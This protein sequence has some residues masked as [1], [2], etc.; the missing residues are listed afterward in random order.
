MLCFLLLSPPQCYY[1]RLI[2]Q[3]ASPANSISH[4]HSPPPPPWEPLIEPYDLPQI[5]DNLQL[6]PALQKVCSCAQRLQLT[7]AE[8]GPLLIPHAHVNT[9]W[10]QDLTPSTRQLVQDLT[11]CSNSR[12]PNAHP[13]KT[14][15]ISVPEALPVTKSRHLNTIAKTQ[16]TQIIHLPQKSCSLREETF[17]A[18]KTMISK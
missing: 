16:T 17:M 12:D 1:T 2:P 10:L 6:E 15:H 14:R 3:F 5:S 11:N 13:T 18:H 9:K 8:L 4:P 7:L